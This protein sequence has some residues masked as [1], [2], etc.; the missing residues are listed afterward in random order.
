MQNSFIKIGEH[1]FEIQ[2]HF[3]KSDKDFI[4]KQYS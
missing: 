3:S 1:V 2:Q 4:N